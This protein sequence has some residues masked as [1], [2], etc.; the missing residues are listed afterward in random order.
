MYIDAGTFNLT[1]I[2]HFYGEVSETLPMSTEFNTFFG[3]LKQRKANAKQKKLCLVAFSSGKELEDTFIAKTRLQEMGY[4]AIFPT[5]ILSDGSGISQDVSQFLTEEIAP[6]RQNDK[7][8]V[9][10]S[11]SKLDNTPLILGRMSIT[12]TY[13]LVDQTIVDMPSSVKGYVAMGP[14]KFLAGIGYLWDYKGRT[15]GDSEETMVRLKA[16]K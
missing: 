5:N 15:C 2:M 9:I 16:L 14:S 6:L 10:M 3:S 1:R 13:C 8:L 4:K 7:I 12:G 11:L